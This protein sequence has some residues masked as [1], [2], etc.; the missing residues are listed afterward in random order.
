MEFSRTRG[1]QPTGGYHVTIPI[2]LARRAFR[3]FS[4]SSS[5]LSNPHPR[6][7][8]PLC[9]EAWRSRRATQHLRERSRAHEKPRGSETYI[10]ET[11]RFNPSR[12]AQRNFKLSLLSYSQASVT[13]WWAFEVQL[14]PS[15]LPKA[16]PNRGPPRGASNLTPGIKRPVKIFF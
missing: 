16:D 9:N 15:Q 3:G 14:I 13:N 1:S 10:Y 5:S 4:P 2:S 6:S 12:G 8:T 7:S 11:Q